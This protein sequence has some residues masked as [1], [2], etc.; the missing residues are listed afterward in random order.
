MDPSHVFE[1]CW[2]SVGLV[3]SYFPLCLMVLQGRIPM[4][5]GLRHMLGARPPQPPNPIYERP[6]TY[7]PHE[8]LIIFDLIRSWPYF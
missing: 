4:L 7:L 5:R 8:D 2:P 1:N 6:L 3:K